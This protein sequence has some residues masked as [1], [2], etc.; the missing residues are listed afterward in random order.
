M[1]GRDRELAQIRS[2]RMRPSPAPA[3]SC[4]SPAS[5][6]RKTRL[7]SEFRASSRTDRHPTAGRA[8]AGGK[9]VSYGESMTY[10]PFRDLS[11]SWLGVL[12]DEPE[13]RVRV[14]LR[15]QIERLFGDRA[16]EHY[17]YL[18]AMLGLTLEPDAQERL[19]ELL[20]RSST[21][22]S[23]WSGTGCSASRDGPVAVSL[24]D[25][26]WSDPTSL[27][28]IERML[29]TPRTPRCSWSSRSGRSGTTPRGA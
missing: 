10:W 19:A 24:E 11:R 8:L 7:I 14:A 29:R 9:C 4:S 16:P 23:R 5:R 25:L 15:R 3:R 18:A 17:P 12:A 26:H 22:R 20:R 13:M 2:S 21:G 6:D 27:Q 28:L 1:V